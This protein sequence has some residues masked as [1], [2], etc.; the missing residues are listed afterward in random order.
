MGGRKVYEQ[1]ENDII[2]QI[3]SPLGQVLCFPVDVEGQKRQT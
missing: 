1:M 3:M 2:H